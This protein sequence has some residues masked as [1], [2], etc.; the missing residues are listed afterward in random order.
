MYILYLTGTEKKQLTPE[1]WH[2]FSKKMVGIRKSL[3]GDLFL[4]TIGIKLMQP[5]ERVLVVEAGTEPHN[6]S[7]QL[8]EVIPGGRVMAKMA[9][10]IEGLSKFIRQRQNKTLKSNVIIAFINQTERSM[11][12]SVGVVFLKDF[13]RGN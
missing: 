2:E 5:T 13:T 4:S 12:V 3:N 1:T 10:I 6:L 7:R 9:R 8:N 11:G